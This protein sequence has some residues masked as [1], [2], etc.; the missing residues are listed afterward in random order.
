[1]VMV[2]FVVMLHVVMDTVLEVKAMVDLILGPQSQLLQDQ[3]LAM[4]PCCLCNNNNGQVK[5]PV[6]NEDLMQIITTLVAKSRMLEKKHSR[7]KDCQV[8]TLCT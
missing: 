2:D 3:D 4:L 8:C 7:H 5:W 1:M 6:N